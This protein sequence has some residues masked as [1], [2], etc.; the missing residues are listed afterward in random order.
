MGLLAHQGVGAVP[1]SPLAKG[2][3]TKPW[4]TSTSRNSNDAVADATFVEADKPVVDAVEA[5]AAERGVTM[6]QVALAWVLRHPVVSAPIVGATK[7]AHLDDAVAAL[8]IDLT[9]DE[10]T[11]LEEHYA[12]R[13]PRGF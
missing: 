4:G 7:A 8:D 3:V 9:D 2:K 10:V 12:I 13:S 11:A 6:A 1:Y 5:I